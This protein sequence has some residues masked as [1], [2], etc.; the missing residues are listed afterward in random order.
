[1]SLNTFDVENGNKSQFTEFYT[2]V[3]T[4]GNNN[5]ILYISNIPDLKNVRCFTNIDCDKFLNENIQNSIFI[6]PELTI[7][8]TIILTLKDI[9]AKIKLLIDVDYIKSIIT[10][11]KFSSIPLIDPPYVYNKRCEGNEWRDGMPIDP[12]LLE[13]IPEDKRVQ[14]GN[15]CYF[16][17]T[18]IDIVNSNKPENPLTRER[19]PQ[20]I[21]DKYRTVIPTFILIDNNEY[22]IING[23]L[24]L[25]TSNITDL[26]IISHLA[27]FIK[28]LN[29]SNLMVR[30]LSPIKDFIK[31]QE[32]IISESHVDNIDVIKEFPELRIFEASNC[33][34]LND[35]RPVSHCQ[36][37]TH[38]DF[39]SSNL[40]YLDFLRNCYSLIYIH[41]A[42]NPIEDIEFIRNINSVKILNIGETGVTDLSVLADKIYLEEL[43]IDNCPINNLEALRNKPNLKELDIEYSDVSDLSSLRGL[44]NLTNI[45]ISN[46]NITD[47]S[48]LLDCPKLK[49][50]K[51]IDIKTNNYGELLKMPSLKF[52]IVNENRKIYGEYAHDLYSEDSDDEDDEEDE[53]EEGEE[54][55]EEN[56]MD[57]S[58]NGENEVDYIHN[59]D[60]NVNQHRGNHYNNDDDFD[61]A[62]DVFER[63]LV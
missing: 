43:C 23:K 44:P 31:L 30:D 60:G 40:H 2:K 7:F 41:I 36:S 16:E 19:L 33:R 49:R 56:I 4:L 8:N 10:L 32:L 1:M 57:V 54:G 61:D 12:I 20:D 5:F 50:V 58:N 14:L 13:P 63:Y 29:I 46:C 52:I 37:L 18:V 55:E 42:D 53:Y 62:I 34:N 39:H 27:P 22:L 3:R 38:V 17:S 11:E 45:I 47:I 6:D 21:F 26:Q 15:T 51:L 35:F 24:N 48:P 28:S 9:K 25:S 59:N